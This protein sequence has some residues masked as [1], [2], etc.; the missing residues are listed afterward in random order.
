[1]ITFVRV[2]FFLYVVIV[3]VLSL[4]PSPEE[5]IGDINDKIEHVAA[6]FLYIILFYF[7]FPSA[8]KLFSFLSGFSFGIVIEILQRFSP[9]RIPDIYDIFADLVGLLLG[10]ACIYILNYIKKRY[11]ILYS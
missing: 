5:I 8:S 4:Y 11:K 7:S 10:L 1:M 6:F 3:T 9:N 2:L